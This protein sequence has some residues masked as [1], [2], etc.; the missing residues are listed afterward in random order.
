M[1]R[2]ATALGL[3]LL[4]S[5]PVVAQ[6]EFEPTAAERK[7]IDDCIARQQEIRNSSR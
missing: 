7:T 4:M 2:I 1:H 3:L 5:A 6:K